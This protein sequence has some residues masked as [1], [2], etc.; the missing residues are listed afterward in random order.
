L[1]LVLDVRRA[2]QFLQQ[3]AL[4]LVQFA[5]SLDT[6]LDEQVAFAMAIQHWHAFTADSHRGTRL[7]SLGNLQGVLTFEGGN[8]NLGSECSLAE[9][10]RNHAVQVGAFALKERMLLNVQNH[11]EITRRAAE[12]SSFAQAGEADAGAVFHSRGN[13]GLDCS[14]AQDTPLSFALGARVGDHAAR[15]L[16]GG[17]S[18]GHAEES[19]LVAHLSASRAGTAGDRRFALGSA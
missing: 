9:R 3:L 1:R 5:G 11:K 2:F 15:A 7:H 10:H 18:A 8:T 12:P 16:T 13:L 17:T 4:P 19:L 6:N 14:V